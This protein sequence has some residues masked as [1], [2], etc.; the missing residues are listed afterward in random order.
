MVH[1]VIKLSFWHP[2][3]RR[4]LNVGQNGV[5]YLIN[6]PLS[7]LQVKILSIFCLQ[8]KREIKDDCV[9]QFLSENLTDEIRSSYSF[10]F[11]D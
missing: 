4:G 6:S 7:N 9:G 5:T 3:R 1:I 11:N 8:K 2:R 10:H